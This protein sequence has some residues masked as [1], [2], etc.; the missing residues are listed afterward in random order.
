[1][2]NWRSSV[3]VGCRLSFVLSLLIVA[4]HASA[5]GQA[6]RQPFS[7]TVTTPQSIITAGAE[8]RVQVTLKNIT[9]HDI[10]V[11]RDFARETAERNYVIDVRDESGQIAPDTAYN[12]KRKDPG[13]AKHPN[14]RYGSH[15]LETLKPGEE[16][17][18]DAVVT[19]LYDITL[20]GKY[21]LQVS[22]Q[23]SDAPGGNIVKSNKI[24]I[25]VTE[26]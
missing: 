16:L 21:S 9:D 17:N 1:V 14:V 11:S 19:K 20:P 10:F 24:G 5:P 7:L 18:D 13:D 25:T 22:R 15:M 3:L 2:N 6:A 12:R 4:T 8:L 23:S 26:F